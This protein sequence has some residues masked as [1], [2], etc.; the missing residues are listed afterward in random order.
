MKQAKEYYNV[1][2]VDGSKMNDLEVVDLLTELYEASK[3]K[4]NNL[5]KK[6]N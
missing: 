1:G 2:N 5:Q 6:L 3:N 4:N